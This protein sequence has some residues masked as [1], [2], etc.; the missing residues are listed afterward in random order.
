[1]NK[2]KARLHCGGNRYIE[3]E[4]SYQLGGWNYFQGRNVERG[5]YLGCAPVEV[6]EG[7]T[8]RTA[9]TGTSL[10]ILPVSR[11]SK[12]AEKTALELAKFKLHDLV[13]H[14]CMKNTLTV[15]DGELEKIKEVFV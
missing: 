3:L 10:L 12:A 11:K 6:G 7:W 2:N 8:S 4:L 9:F 14:V 5:Y 13:M 15:K 1:M